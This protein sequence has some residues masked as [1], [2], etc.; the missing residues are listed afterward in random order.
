MWWWATSASFAGLARAVGERRFIEPRLTG[1]FAYASCSPRASDGRSIARVLCSK[2]PI[3]GS[4][5]AKELRA[6]LRGF[7]AESTGAESYHRNGVGDLLGGQDERSAARA[8]A[9]LEEARRRS[10]EDARTRSDLAASLFVLAQERDEPA[11]LVRALAA[12]SEATRLDPGLPEA[13]FNR[14]LILDRLF[15]TDGARHAWEDFLRLDGTS[16]WADEA[17]QHQA[18][19]AESQ[20]PTRWTQ[21]LSSLRE[22]ALRG[23]GAK[24][25]ELVRLSPQAAREHA[26]ED[27]LGEWGD[28]VLGKPVDA[29]I[30]L[31]VARS[32][33][34]A[35]RAETGERV[36]AESVALID[37]SSG[38]PILPSFAAGHQAYRDGWHAYRDQSFAEAEPLL[39]KAYEAFRQAGSPL[40][41]WALLP[42]AGIDLTS[43]R[44]E[45]ALQRYDVIRIAAKRSESRALAGC[46]D[47]GTGLIRF[48]QRLFSESLSRFL[49]ASAAFETSREQQNLGA[50]LELISENLRF[51]G[52]G[53]TAWKY[54]Y[55]AAAALAP[56]R[57][58][59]RLHSL[60]WEGGWSTVE[61]GEARAGLDFL[62]EGVG[63]GERSHLPLRLAEALL[64]RSKIHLALE[65]GVKAL[66]DLLRSRKENLKTPDRTMSTR[67]AAD[68][69]YVEGEVRR[70][71]DPETAREPLK[72][73]VGFY[74]ANGLLLDLPDAYLAR[75]QTEKAGGRAGEAHANIEAALALFERSQGSLTDPS[76]RL[77]MAEKVQG[78]YDE[79]LL[80]QASREGE[81]AAL[82]TVER[83]RALGASS[84]SA[85]LTEKLA[86]LPRNLA[87]LEYARVGDRFFT[88]L[89]HEGLVES[90]SLSDAD[91]EEKVRAFVTA[92]RQRD[93]SVDAKA[94]ELHR[95][96]IPE[97][98]ST[99]PVETEIVIIPDKALNTLP[100]AALKDPG[101]G[102]YLIEDRTIRISSSLAFRSENSAEA[103]GLKTALLVA[104]TQFDVKSFP[105]L[106][107]LPG[108]AQ[109]VTDLKGLYRDSRVLAGADAT[110][111][112]LLA[113]LD[114]KRIL[115]FAGHAVFNSR[116]P[117]YSYFVL[118]PAQ[119]PADDGVLFL[120]E[121][122]GRRFDHLRLV[123][124]SACSTVGPLDTRTGGV[125]GLARPFLDAGAEAVVG[126]LWNANDQAAAQM[127]PDFHRRYLASGNAAEALRRAQLAML[128]S[129]DPLKKKPD[130]WAVFQV[131]TAR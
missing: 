57:D 18:A 51:L 130:S 55:R 111:A 8:V 40:E 32:I 47:W 75:F 80:L 115:H 93:A 36:I 10:P 64:W 53:A 39:A 98:L 29:E 71:F 81:A 56:Y 108:A 86:A 99:L 114:S 20:P 120:Y 24:V 100:F 90:S 78:L 31:R 112:H 61:D 92:I 9:A 45:V 2:P 123:V 46:A 15:L 16:A 5:A 48:R 131:V 102:H 63:L 14:A 73:A 87:V 25:R 96:L 23:D 34:A 33:G 121:I 27:L 72:R 117:D 43:G 12:A 89:I 124:L 65:D 26:A 62:N 41:P 107:S 42:L 3:P 52:Q 35:L 109:E 69:D 128:Q 104:G 82:E 44:R 54:R 1:G 60:L 105:A 110:K 30:P 66:D 74:E 127:L 13:R 79:L 19:L 91:L 85:S 103:A 97:S 50:A 125:S 77:S 7:Q 17:R 101:T 6:A 67:L 68:L 70:R 119:N 22:A 59:I 126:A 122:A 83:A 37:R 76:Q 106:P 113:E 84:S 28:L 94:R 116:H 11:I 21:S 118:A 38:G 58:S 4:P 129:A 49:S 95:L 88:W